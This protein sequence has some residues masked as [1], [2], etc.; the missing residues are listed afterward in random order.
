MPTSYRYSLLSIV[1]S[2]TAVSGGEHF[3][4]ELVYGD[5]CKAV[6]LIFFLN[7]FY[8]RDLWLAFTEPLGFAEPRLKTTVPVSQ[9]KP[10]IAPI[11]QAI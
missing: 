10:R 5:F 8:W 11:R 9:L 6:G 3:S 2:I 1:Y 4:A 7:I